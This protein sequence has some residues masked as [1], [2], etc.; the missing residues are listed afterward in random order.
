LNDIS[1]TG[2]QHLADALR[3]NTVTSI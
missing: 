3:K 1:A 2:M